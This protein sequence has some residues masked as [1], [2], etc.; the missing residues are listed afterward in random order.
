MFLGLVVTFLLPETKGKTLE[1]L[2]GE[3][4]DLDEPKID[5]NQEKKNLKEKIQSF[6]RRK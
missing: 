4:D 5:S 3:R 2:N 1:Q 6:F